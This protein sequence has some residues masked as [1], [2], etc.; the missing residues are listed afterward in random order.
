MG[1]ANY[2]SLQTSLKRT[3]GRFTFLASYTYGKSMTDFQ[4]SRAGQSL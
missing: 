3:A 2:N 4:H 1:N